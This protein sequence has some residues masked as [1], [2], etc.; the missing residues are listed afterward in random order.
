MREVF[1][2]H[3]PS[4]CFF[5]GDFWRTYLF[6]NCS[7]F[8]LLGLILCAVYISQKIEIRFRAKIANGIRSGGSALEKAISL[9]LMAL[10]SLYTFVLSNSMSAFRCFLQGDGSYTL[11]SSPDLNCYDSSW[12]SN[13]FSIFLGMIVTISVPCVV[14]WILYS[15]RSLKSRQSNHFYWKFGFLCSPYRHDYYW[16]EAIVLLKKGFFVIFID[17]SSN[18][19]L[20]ERTF[21]LIVYFA[22]EIVIDSI[23]FPYRMESKSVLQIKI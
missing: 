13:L 7:P 20:F 1:G 11:V 14:C 18:L 6:R 17:I 10:T 21:V 8:L 12:N 16:W 4:G 9:Y 3:F 19:S 15:H 23:I 5:G 2:L 22:F